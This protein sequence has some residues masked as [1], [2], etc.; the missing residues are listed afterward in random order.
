MDQGVTDRAKHETG[1]ST[2]A[3][4]ADHDQAGLAGGLRQRVRR[5]GTAH[6]AAS[7]TSVYSAGRSP[8][9]SPTTSGAGGAGYRP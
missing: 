3:T 9:V 7:G 1:E 5:I 8:S 6:D 4:R 2:Q